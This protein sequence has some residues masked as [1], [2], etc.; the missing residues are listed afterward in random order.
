M[1]VHGAGD[2][3]AGAFLFAITEGKDLVAAGELA[4]RASAAVVSEYGS[5][6]SK[7]KQQEILLEWSN[8]SKK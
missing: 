8:M 7:Q 3:F 1:L 2:M 6:L 4:S 5:R